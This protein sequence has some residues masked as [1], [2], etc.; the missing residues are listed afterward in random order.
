MSGDED[1]LDLEATTEARSF[2]DEQGRSDPASERPPPDREEAV[3]PSQDPSDP[4]RQVTP[5]DLSADAAAIDAEYAV[6]ASP[7]TG[8]VIIDDDGFTEAVEAWQEADE[9]GQQGDGPFAVAV[10]GPRPRR[11]DVK[12][13]LMAEAFAMPVTYVTPERPG[14]PVR[15]S[16]R[17]LDLDPSAPSLWSHPE[18]DPSPNVEAPDTGV[19]R[20]P[21]GRAGPRAAPR[22]APSSST[23]GQ[24]RRAPQ[25]RQYPQMLALLE[26]QRVA[27]RPGGHTPK[28]P[29]PVPGTFFP[30]PREP[31]EQPEPTDL[32]QLLHT[33]AEGLLIGETSDG[34]TEVRV[35]LKDEFFAGTE[36]RIVAGVGR[37]RAVL[38]PPDREVYW[39]LNGSLEALKRRL[40]DRGLD[41]EDIELR[42]P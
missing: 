14:I 10:D 32:D 11:P 4:W 5:L 31:M 38:V 27:R 22:N 34:Q 9:E 39:Q 24:R 12:P 25:P 40:T 37:V 26:D 19:R 21:A 15:R 42:D 36:L 16:P 41:V 2:A 17:T 18:G 3:E 6:A 30:A 23:A 29:P 35:T 33:M 1:Q 8:A 7:P 13:D 28:A 20:R